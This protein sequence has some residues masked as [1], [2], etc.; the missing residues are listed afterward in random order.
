MLNQNK[1]IYN[2]KI[3]PLPLIIK[4][5]KQLYNLIVFYKIIN[6]IFEFFPILFSHDTID[7]VAPVPTL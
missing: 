2:N 5:F 1:C 6:S 7:I 4:K 3:I